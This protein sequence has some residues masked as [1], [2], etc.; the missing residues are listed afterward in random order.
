MARTGLDGVPAPETCSP[1]PRALLGCWEPRGLWA[2]QL[3]P[4]GRKG[5]GCGVKKVHLGKEREEER[6]SKRGVAP[7]LWGGSPRDAPGKNLPKR[8]G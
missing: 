8:G 3:E 1:A 7:R 4:A 5:G 6:E 2:A